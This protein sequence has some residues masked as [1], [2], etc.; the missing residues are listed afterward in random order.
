M[1]DEQINS[2]ARQILGCNSGT[3]LSNFDAGY[4]NAARLGA[5]FYLAMTDNLNQE[6][7]H[8]HAQIKKLERDKARLDWLNHHGDDIYYH[9][10]HIHND[11]VDG[12]GLLLRQ[13]IDEAITRFPDMPT[14]KAGG[15]E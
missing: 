2:I 6:L 10:R 4:Q 5:R 1:I 13:A 12:T 14:T 15:G 8:L 9:H 7:T 3:M 11:H